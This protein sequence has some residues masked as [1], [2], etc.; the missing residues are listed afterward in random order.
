MT[1]AF[2]EVLLPISTA[3]AQHQ[4]QTFTESSGSLTVNYPLGWKIIQPPEDPQGSS[5]IFS[6]P[7]GGG[8]SLNIVVGPD[9]ARTA[10]TIALK[11]MQKCNWITY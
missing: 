3:M 6:N 9:Q 11:S 1:I 8:E 5:V 10:I 2:L 4:I 7:H